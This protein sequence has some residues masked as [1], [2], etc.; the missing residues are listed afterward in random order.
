MWQWLDPI[1]CCLAPPS[2][3]CAVTADRRQFRHVVLMADELSIGRNRGEAHL[4]HP[5]FP[6]RRLRLT[7][8]ADGLHAEA[9][10]G[11]VFFDDGQDDRVTDRPLVLPADLTLYADGAGLAQAALLGESDVYEMRLQL[12]AVP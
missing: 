11:A 3:A 7:W 12:G 10:G 6:A 4:V 5:Q 2:P 9:E 1:K 8:R